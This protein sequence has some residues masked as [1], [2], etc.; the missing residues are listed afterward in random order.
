MWLVK[1][2]RSLEK[3][4][5]QRPVLPSPRDITLKLGP[6]GNSPLKSE[7][8]PETPFTSDRVT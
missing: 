8:R 6:T 5:E 1:I 4:A 7:G 3:L 2:A